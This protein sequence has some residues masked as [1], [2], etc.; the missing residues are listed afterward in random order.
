[1]IKVMIVEDEP[2]FLNR[3]LAFDEDGFARLFVLRQGADGQVFGYAV[4]NDFSLRDFVAP[5][6]HPLGLDAVIGKGWD[7]AAP[8]GPCPKNGRNFSSSSTSLAL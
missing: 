5:F 6:P 2:A 7:G 1:M 8:I 3:P 4:L